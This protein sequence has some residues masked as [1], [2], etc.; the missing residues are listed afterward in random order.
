MH[1]AVQGPIEGLSCEPTSALT[2]EQLRKR[3]LENPKSRHI[4][5]LKPEPHGP[6]SPL[7]WSVQS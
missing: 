6:S 7:I 5:M 4:L 2:Q 3:R 1:V